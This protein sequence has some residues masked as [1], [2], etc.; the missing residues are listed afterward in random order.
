MQVAL[1]TGVIAGLAG[2]TAR[3]A[4]RRS[5]W[6]TLLPALPLVALTGTL[7]SYLQA[8][9]SGKFAVWERLL[10]EL[11]LTGTERV[12]D[13]GCGRGAILCAAA[14]RLTGGYAAGV[15]LWR[16]DQSGNSAAATWRNVELE[17][18]G[19]SV[20]LLTADMT[21]LPFP[22]ASFDVVVSSLAVHNV[23]GRKG[24]EAAVTE[25]S[26]V[27]RAGGRVVLVDLGFTRQHAQGFE[28]A[29]LVDVRR[30]NAGPRFWFGGPWFPAHVVTARRP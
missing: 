10:D 12:L 26:R 11:E 7:A 30:R 28:G 3:G 4:L 21:R 15:D 6:Q 29:G 25:A 2:L 8:S 24:R 18:V 17:G 5:P 9:L 27:L 19:G 23:P 14:R 13:L 1:F 20:W 16:P 22:D